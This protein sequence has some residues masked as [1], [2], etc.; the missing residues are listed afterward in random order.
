MTIMYVIPIK[1]AISPSL[2]YSK[3]VLY[4]FEKELSKI[5]V[6]H[7]VIDF[8]EVESMSYSFAHQYITCKKQNTRNKI[9]EINVPDNISILLELVRQEIDQSNDQI[10]N[11]KKISDIT[12]SLVVRN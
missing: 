3:E 4:F 7:V 6:D 11:K 5:I 2:S 8:S 12:S 10:M 1:Y 9:R